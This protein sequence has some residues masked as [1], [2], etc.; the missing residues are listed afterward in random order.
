MDVFEEKIHSYR[1]RHHGFHLPLLIYRWTTLQGVVRARHQPSLRADTWTEQHSNLDILLIG[2]PPPHRHCHCHC[3]CH[4]HPP[5]PRHIL[6]PGCRRGLRPIN[7]G[8]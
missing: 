7:N 5:H 8:M 2:R 3:H 4:R 6:F 1:H